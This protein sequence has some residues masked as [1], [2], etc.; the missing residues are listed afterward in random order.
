MDQLRKQLV[1]MS[2]VHAKQ[3]GFTELAIV[4]ACQE[5]GYASTSTGVV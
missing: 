1:K 4:E 5:L 2:F 3:H